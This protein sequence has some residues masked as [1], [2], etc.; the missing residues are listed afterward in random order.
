MVTVALKLK[1]LAPWRKAMRNLDSVLKSRDI[2]SLTKVCLV[3]VMVLPVV[4][5]GCD[6]WTIKKA[7]MWHLVPSLHGK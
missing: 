7:E 3:K 2:T 4:M 1:T 5:C 6:S